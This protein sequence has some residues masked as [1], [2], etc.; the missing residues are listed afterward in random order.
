MYVCVCIC[1]TRKDHSPFNVRYTVA[2]TEATHLSFCA[3]ER[4]LRHPRHIWAII[5]AAQI[6]KLWGKS[7]LLPWRT[8]LS[9]PMGTPTFSHCL[10]HCHNSMHSSFISTSFTSVLCSQEDSIAESQ[11]NQLPIQYLEIFQSEQKAHLG[12]SKLGFRI[13][14]KD[15]REKSSKE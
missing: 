11:K 9:G 8:S 10:L 15:P 1:K 7:A 12:E 2:Y 14:Q 3:K 5:G 4:S 13:S 6:Q